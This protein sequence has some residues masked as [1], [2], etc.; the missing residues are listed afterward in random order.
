MESQVAGRSF[1]PSLAA[2]ADRSG[3][4][5]TPLHPI[6]ATVVSQYV[7]GK[8]RLADVTISA[9]HEISISGKQLLVAFA[10]AF[11]LAGPLVWSFVR[12]LFAP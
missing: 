1:S 2:P 3:R 8:D 10:A 6:T 5:S 11:C 7:G 12:W 9:K 4:A